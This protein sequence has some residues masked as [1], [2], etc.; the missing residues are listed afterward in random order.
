MKAS[1]FTIAAS[2]VLAITA[3]PAANADP[4]DCQTAQFSSEVLAKFPNIAKTCLD[5]I[6]KDGQDYAVVKADLVRTRPGA[7]TV[8]VKMPDG[9]R[10]DS[11]IIRTAP[12]RRV[13]V[14]GK[15]VRVEDLAVGQE[16]TA[17]VKVT[18]PEIALAPVEPTAP[19]ESSPMEEAAPAPAETAST[20]TT[21]PTTASPFPAI[22]LAGFGLILAGTLL[23]F[24]RRRNARS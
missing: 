9:T 3:I 2:A 17:Y 7:V 16:I 6:N 14:D 10:S 18:Q 23:G 22:G 11:M 20:A 13:L 19:I 5:I 12:G 24:A 21:M 15:E 8:R 1:L 4:A